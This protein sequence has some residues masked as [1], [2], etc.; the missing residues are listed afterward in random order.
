MEL[1]FGCKL[2]F[3]KGKILLQF[4]TTHDLFQ[5]L[6]QTRSSPSTWRNVK[7]KPFN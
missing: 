5:I 7:A 3:A 2:K 1:F 6:Y 4:I